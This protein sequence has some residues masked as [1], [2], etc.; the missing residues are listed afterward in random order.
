[1]G[2]RSG[3]SREGEW[4]GP[5]QGGKELESAFGMNVVESGD[6]DLGSMLSNGCDG[7]RG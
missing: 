3:I 1:M 6:L 5:G 7:G 2:C 4:W